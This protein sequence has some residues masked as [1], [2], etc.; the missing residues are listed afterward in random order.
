MSRYY[1][2]SVEISEYDPAK[3]KEIQAAAKAEWPLEDWWSANDEPGEAMHA[4]AQGNLSGGESEEAF[5]ERLSL[6]VWRANGGY[7]G[8]TV[9]A[10]Y[11]ENLP[12]ETHSLDRSDY[13]RLIRAN[14]RNEE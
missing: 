3:A 1:D 7:C 11:L 4:S 6:A 8:V 5:T 9:D 10:T 2:M 14:R 12:Y 13:D